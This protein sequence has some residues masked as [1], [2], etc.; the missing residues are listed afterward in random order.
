MAKRNWF[1]KQS[2]ENHHRDTP[3]YPITLQAGVGGHE[4]NQPNFGTVH[5]NRLRGGRG[6]LPHECAAAAAAAALRLLVRHTSDIPLPPAA[7]MTSTATV[8]LAARRHG[9]GKLLE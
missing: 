1:D 3:R 8:G 9:N 4:I 7:A 5:D 2:T 6:F